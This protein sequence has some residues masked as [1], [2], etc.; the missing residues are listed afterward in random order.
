[1]V[2]QKFKTISMK[3]Q[4]C[5]VYVL[6]T[7][8]GWMAPQTGKAQQDS[9]LNNN[10]VQKTWD[11]DSVLNE[12]PAIQ[13]L[14]SLQQLEQET[15]NKLKPL[16]R[17]D[18]TI[19]LN[20]IDTLSVLQKAQQML[21]D[22]QDSAR[23]LAGFPQEKLAALIDSEKTKTSTWIEERMKFQEQWQEKLSHLDDKQKALLEKTPISGLD[24]TTLTDEIPINDWEG[25]LQ[26]V[27]ID[28]PAVEEEL[29]QLDIDLDMQ[30]LDQYTQF[31]INEKLGELPEIDGLKSQINELKGHEAVE[32]LEEVKDSDNLDQAV[33]QQV[34]K[35]QLFV[36]GTEELSAAQEVEYEYFKVKD[37]AVQRREMMKKAQL[38]ANDVLQE[39]PE[40]VQQSQQHIGKMKKLYGNV[41]SGRD[42]ITGEEVP[43]PKWKEQKRWRYGGNFQII[44]TDP[45]QMDASPFVSYQVARILQL[46]VGITGRLEVKET[47]D[48]SI[49]A[50]EKGWTYGARLFGQFGKVKGFFA[51]LEWENTKLRESNGIQQN[52]L[53][54][55]GR[56][57]RI[58]EKVS[59]ALLALYNINHGDNEV[60]RSPWVFRFGVKF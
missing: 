42:V 10:T 20:P 40:L 7:L 29:D 27:N 56:D 35:H 48:G 17:I 25:Y 12:L 32:A 37:P 33:E 53:A 44:S 31:D 28:M 9:I 14:D 22:Y 30:Q 45:F 6:L 13:T 38:L 26:E 47:S 50:N 52:F 4:R 43:T 15:R 23:T 11:V 36:E 18:T 1:M 51:H 60:Y 34:S 41:K 24:M 49:A 19:D 59:S 16:T 2:V 8:L 55:I 46:G 58:T 54:G 57:L 39:Q 21:Q 3:L 5:Y